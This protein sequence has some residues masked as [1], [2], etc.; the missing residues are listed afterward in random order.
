MVFMGAT[1]LESLTADPLK[2][3]VCCKALMV[4]MGAT[5]LESLTSDSL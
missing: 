1:I 5:I 3:L 4:L 2:E